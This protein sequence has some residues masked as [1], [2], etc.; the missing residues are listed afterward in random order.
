MTVRAVFFDVGETVV[1]ETRLWSGWADWLKVPRLTFM[2]VLGGLIERGED[3]RLVFE[4]F[5][6]DLAKERAARIAAGDPP[7]LEPA[8]LYPDARPALQRLRAEGFLVGIAGNQPARAEAFLNGLEP[9]V[10][11]TTTSETLGA[12]KPALEFFHRLAERAGV[13]PSA[14]AYVGDRVDNDVV[15]AKRAGMKAIFIRRGPWGYLHAL[16]P[17]I[18]LADAMIDSLEELPEVL[19]SL[20]DQD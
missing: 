18:E 17:E 14:A 11:F 3:H 13:E 2:G 12:E 6:V 8:D 9:L 7:R 20:G 15:P 16:R 1:D 10:D 19:T 4:A 5:G